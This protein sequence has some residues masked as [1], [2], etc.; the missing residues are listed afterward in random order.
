MRRRA[1]STSRHA[2]MSDSRRT[3]SR[4]TTPQ[5]SSNWRANAS[6]VLP[7]APAPAH[8]H[9]RPP[10]RP[11][12]APAP[13]APTGPPH[14]AGARPEP[15]L[16]PAALRIDEGAQV[17]EAVGGDQPGRHELPQTVLHLA[18]QPPVPATSSRRKD[19]PGGGGHRAP[20][21]P[22]GTARRPAP[23]PT[24][25]VPGRR[26]QP[27]QVFPQEERDRRD[28]GRP[29]PPPAAEGLAD[30]ASTSTTS[31]A[32][33]GDRRPHITSPERQSRSSSSGS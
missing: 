9:P 29:Y 21:R 30:S 10:P 1:P 23:R 32:G 24:G 18:R 6:P 22:D 2:G 25:I 13:A 26:H 8:H 3:R 19:A 16:A 27:L 15:A 7:G 33:C 20:P 31:K 14:D 17:V 28:A 5:R 11:P 4:N 12:P